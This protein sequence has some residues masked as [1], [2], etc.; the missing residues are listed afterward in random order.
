MRRIGLTPRELQVADA[1]ATR[2][3]E[4]AEL[5][6]IFGISRKTLKYHALRVYEKLYVK[7]RA[8]LALYW[9][10]EIFQAGVEAL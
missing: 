8:E 9:R 1:L 6:K 5:A 4:Y 7:N 10:C 3:E 2:P